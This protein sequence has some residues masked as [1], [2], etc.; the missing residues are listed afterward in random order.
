MGGSTSLAR[1]LPRR[2]AAPTHIPNWY[3]LPVVLRKV[4]PYLASRSWATSSYSERFLM[5]K[6]STPQ[7]VTRTKRLSL[8]VVRLSAWK[9]HPLNASWVSRLAGSSR[10]RLRKTESNSRCPQALR[11]P[12]HLNLT[13]RRLEALLSRMAPLCQQILSF[14]VLVLGLQPH[15]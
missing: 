12:S 1:R 5:S 14:L 9:K 10:N 8:S 7:L 3:L 6:P 13:H 11:R 15:T 2:A 4:S